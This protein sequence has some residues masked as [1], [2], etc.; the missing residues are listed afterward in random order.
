MVI[1]SLSGPIKVVAIGNCLIDSTK[2]LGQIGSPPSGQPIVVVGNVL[3]L[4]FLALADHVIFVI[5]S[6]KRPPGFRNKFSHFAWVRPAILKVSGHKDQVRI[7]PIDVCCDRFQSR[8]I[9]VDVREHGDLHRT[10]T[11]SQITFLDKF[12]RFT[13]AHPAEIVDEHR[14]GIRRQ[15]VPELF[16][17]FRSL[18]Q[19]CQVSVWILIS[20]LMIGD[21]GKPIP[22]CLREYNVVLIHG[23]KVSPGRGCIQGVSQ[24]AER[25]PASN[26]LGWG[27]TS[28]KCS[29]VSSCS[30]CSNALRQTVGWWPS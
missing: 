12:E 7:E 19:S 23:C 25:R 30:N 8:Q 22:Q 17:P 2:S 14:I 10:V 28:L 3:A 9:S 6:Q 29:A 11:L 15:S 20:K 26:S 13:Q 21:N 5:S 18:L 4:E 1:E 16:D 24:E 27:R